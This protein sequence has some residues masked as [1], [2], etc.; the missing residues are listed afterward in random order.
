MKKVIACCFL[1]VLITNLDAQEYIS[2]PLDN[3]AYDIIEMG[4][5]RGMIK[6]PPSAKPWSVNVV[7]QKLWEMMDD[8][9]EVLSPKEAGMLDHAYES[10]E[11]KEEFEF[12]FS[13]ESDFSVKAPD[14]SIS[15]VNLAKLSA[16]GNATKFLS[17]DLTVLGEFLYIERDEAGVPSMFP[18]TMSKMWDGGVLSL[19]N[20][21]AYFAWPED[22]SLAIGLQGELSGVF[23]KE[24]LQFRFGRLRRDWGSGTSGSSLFMNAQS[25][26]FL[27]VEGVIS[28]LSWMDISFL[29]GVTEYYQNVNEWPRQDDSFFMNLLSAVQIEFNPLKY[30]YFGIGGSAVWLHHINLAAFANLELRAPGILKVWGS[31]FLDRLDSS[32]DDFPVTNGNSYAYQA[33]LKTVIRWLPFG[34]FT[35]RYT[36]VEPYCYTDSYDGYDGRRL[37]SMAAFVSAGESLGYY[38]PPNSD[39]FLLRLESMFLPDLKVHLQFQMIRH[40]ADYGNGAVPGSSLTDRLADTRSQKHFLEDGVYRWNNVLK[41]GGSYK[42]MIKTVPI[43]VYT[44]IGYVSTSFTTN[45]D[46]GPGDYDKIDDSV[47]RASNSF[48]FS[49]GFRLF[50]R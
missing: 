9:E 47:Y 33:G 24:K 16:R 29:T 28:P 40:G 43:S 6:Q 22:P 31:F 39:E 49:I 8:P 34:S 46:A 45:G 26:P 15:S 1:L 5:L 50:P 41:L 18:Y 17:W 42:F 21:E 27:A 38:I 10:F 19:R 13:W 23:F 3:V 32:T 30:I 25:L 11:R 4:V 14:P 7:K 2:V 44:E 20:A 36:K 35:F 12:L 37:P 48:L